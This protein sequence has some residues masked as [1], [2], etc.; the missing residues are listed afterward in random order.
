MINK[1]N[2]DWHDAIDCTG[3]GKLIH[4]G[5]KR[6]WWKLSIKNHLEYGETLNG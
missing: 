1:Y 3:Y 4:I 5:K 6:R 2:N